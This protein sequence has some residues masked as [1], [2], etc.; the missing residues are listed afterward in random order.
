MKL[1]GSGSR[2]GHPPIRSTPASTADANAARLSAP[3]HPVIGEIASA[4][5]WMSINPLKC[6]LAS[7]KA[8][9]FRAP[10]WPPT[11]T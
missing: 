9:T 1:A 4:T 10:K 3:S 5:N 7:C 2:C 6:D 11:A 8:T